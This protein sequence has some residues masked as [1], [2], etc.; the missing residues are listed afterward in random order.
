MR[1]DQVCVIG[2]IDLEEDEKVDYKKVKGAPVKAIP[3]S[4]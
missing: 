2:E 4:V 1:G 3:H